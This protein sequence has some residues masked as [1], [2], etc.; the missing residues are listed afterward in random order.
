[1]DFKNHPCFDAEAKHLYARIHLP[2]AKECNIQ[3]HYCNRAYS[4]VNESRPGITA[5]ILTPQDAAAYLEKQ[6]ALIPALRVAGIAGPGDPLANPRET[7]L[8]LET[9]HKAHP[10]LLLCVATNGLELATYA[11]DLKDCAVSHVTVTVNTADP[12][13]GALIYKWVRYGKR[14][15]RGIEAAALLLERQTEGIKA[16]KALGITVK[17]NTV[18]I[19]GVNDSRIGEVS[20][21]VS[22]LGADIQNCISMYPA[23]GTALEHNGEPDAATMSRIRADAAA[24][25]KQMQHCTRCRAD[26]AGFLGRDNPAETAK[27]MQ[28]VTG[29][30]E[31]RPYVAVTSLDGVFVNEHLGEAREL[32]IFDLEEKR[33][34]FITK[35]TLPLPGS[36]T[37][38]W[39]VLA[40][41]IKDCRVLLVNGIG[42]NPLGILETAGIK[43]IAMEGLIHPA[44]ENVLTGRD[45]PRCFL[46]TEGECGKAL[47]CSGTGA[48][49][50]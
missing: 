44:V 34:K 31:N 7:L 49:C 46:K 19:R 43:V 25:M 4:C 3:C 16:I 22:S 26:A 42:K 45:I 39:E 50:L 33:V 10:E 37:K 32:W 30:A 29:A 2:V 48:G 47:H 28:A 12:E 18:V 17:I 38:R 11:R 20:R 41:L 27:I 13:T 6:L 40:D 35:R 8:T 9:I 15:Y 23:P 24:Y 36:G 14:V 21:L 5:S 1:M